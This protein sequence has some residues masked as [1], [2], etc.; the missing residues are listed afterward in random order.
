MKQGK[1]IKFEENKR[2]ECDICKNHIDFNMPEE[3]VDAVLNRN[4][5]LFCGAG[6]STESKLVY[7]DTIYMEVLT[8][9]ENEIDEEIDLST[10]FSSL[11]SLYIKTF[12]NGRRKLIHFRNYYT[13]Q[14]CFIKKFLLIH[15]L[16]QS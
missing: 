16:K 9:I 5:V 1:E 11:M 14:L 6:I 13:M 4:L 3:I 15:I 2:C 12:A 8:E 7:P 10:S